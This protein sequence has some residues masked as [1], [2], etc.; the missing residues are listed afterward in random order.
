MFKLK[1][2]YFNFD[3]GLMFLIDWVCFYGIVDLFLE[4]FVIYFEKLV[5][6]IVVEEI[7]LGDILVK[8]EEL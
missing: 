6:D 3:S 2:E 5:V 7:N 1:F 8:I 4:W